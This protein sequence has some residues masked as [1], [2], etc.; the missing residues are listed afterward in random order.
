MKIFDIESDGLLDTITK[1]HCINIID[2]VTGQ[3]L[4]FNGG[5]YYH[6]VTGDYIGP[7]NPD[8]TVD[9]GAAYL[10]G[11]F[12]AGQ[13]IIG[14]D[15]PVLV[16]FYPEFQALEVLDT[17][18][19]AAVIWP[20]LM[21][22]DFNA[23]RNGTL[24]PEFQKL[25]FVGRNSL[26]A[27]G[28]RLDPDGSKGLRK[29]DFDPKEYGHTWETV[30]FSLVMDDYCAQDNEVAYEWIKLIEAK[31]YSPEC[32]RLEH[33]V[34]AIIS[35]QERH[36]F[37]FDVKAA[38]V[39][40]AKLQSRRAALEDQL[41]SVFPPW[42]VIEKEFI[43]KVNNKSLGRVKGDLIVKRKMLVFNPSSRDH[44]A[45][46]LTAIYGWAPEEFTDNGK[47]KVDET[48]LSALPY[49]EAKPLADYLMVSK[50]IGQI[51]E[52]AEGWLR[53]E[54]GG[55]VYGRV[56]TN[57]AVTG[58][59]THFKPNMAQVPNSGA[60][61][62]RECRALFRATKLASGIQLALVGCD[63]EGLELRVLAHFMARWDGGAYANT[64]VNGTK[65]DE[66]D[67]HNVN[68]RAALLNSR[69]AA[70]TFIYALIYGAGDEKLGSIAFEDGTPAQKA[71]FLSRYTTK[72]ARAK[73]LRKLG[74]QRRRSIMD[75]L[76]ALGQLIKAVKAAV[77]E[78]GYLIGL[79]G[80]R[81]HVRS[82]HAALNTLLQSGGAIVMKLA[83]VLFDNA[84]ETDPATAGKVEY[85]ANVHDEFQVETEK[86]IAE[87]IGQ[88]AADAIR[89]A[90]EHFKFRCPLSGA[91]AVGESWNDTH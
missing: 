40:L 37:A 2:T 73:A 79:D 26:A 25:R 58:R 19:C 44:I 12:V 34:A 55:R 74:A 75:N 54:R 64:V 15:L 72:V 23:L 24:P 6:E 81:L 35:R 67:V 5:S 8:G 63:A 46:R 61:Y 7:S 32:L 39:L 57:G 62:G 80:R 65:E 21:D 10:H 33:D 90:G 56:N 52:G 41:Q 20:D 83:L 30:P 22:R 49:P 14:Y 68:K 89:H 86:E 17:K 51:A 28:Y 88:L 70:K 16:K 50:R 36:G 69:D 60:E 1:I 45:S 66:T 85:C 27:W 59:M 71:K 38:E 91:Y 47:P 77:K 48:V 84:V 42:E 87:A 53:N 76:P 78:K 82:D 18:I 3:R 13:N 29:G 4:R 31:N 9:E 11:Q 43:A